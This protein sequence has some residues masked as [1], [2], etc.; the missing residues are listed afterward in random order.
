M[1]ADL[2]IPVKDCRRNKNLKFRPV[3]VP[4]LRNYR[5]VFLL[6]LGCL[7]AT[8]PLSPTAGEALTNSLLLSGSDWWIQGEPAGPGAQQGVFGAT[9]P[10]S[11]W[12]PAT[13]PGNVQADLEEAH[14]LKPLWYGA[15]DS[16]L[17]D[18]AR[19]NWWYRKDFAIP[20][21]FAGKRLTLVFDGV[22]HE[23]E[24]W[25]NRRKI[26]SHVGMFR[27]F[28]SD[29]TELIK[30]GETNRLAVRVSQIPDELAPLIPATDGPQST[31]FV[32]AMNRSRQTLKE[33][34]SPTNFGWDWGVNVWTLGIWKD[35][36]L[37]A[38]GPARIDWTRVQTK[39]DNDCA[40]ATVTAILAV[41]CLAEQGA[42]V[43]CRV[44]GNGQE[45]TASSKVS[46]K[47]G[48][49]EVRLELALD[50]PALW[51]CQGQGAQPLYTLEVQLRPE[52]GGRV[53]DARSIRFGLRDVRWVLTE[54]A[55]NDYISRFQ[56]V[57]NGR[58]V[59]TMGSCLIPPDLLFGRSRP[60]S[61]QLLHRAR[62]A[63]VNML[64]LWGGGIILSEDF[65]ALADELGIMLS[66]EF[67]IANC[68]PETNAVF[69]ANLEATTRNIVRQV[70]N[71]PAIIE[72]TGGNEMSWNS[73][74]RHPAWELFQRIVSEEDDRLIRATCPDLGATH[75]PWDFS[76]GS[77]YR[78][79]NAAQTMRYGEFGTQTPANLEVWH[80]TIPPQSQWPIQGESEPILIRKNVVQAVFSPA[81]WLLKGRI[82]SAF[83][84]LDNLPCLVEAGQFLGAEGLRYAT[85]ALRR[86]GRHLGGFTTWDFN[87]PWPNGAGSYL[88]DYDGRPLMNYDFFR[89]ALAP[90]SLSLKYDS[91]LYDP[92]AGIQLEVW[93][94][95]DAPAAAKN[96]Q[97]QLLARD[98]RGKVFD[99]AQGAAAINPWEASLLQAIHLTPPKETASGP[100][101]VEM[102]LHDAQ[103]KLL[104]ERLHVFGSGAGD[105]GA[106][107][108]MLVNRKAD[109][110]DDV[111]GKAPPERPNGPANLA[112]VGNGAKPATTSSELPGF[113]IHQAKGLNDGIY[114]NDHSWIA[115][116][117]HAWFQID[118]GKIATVGR[119][120]LGRDR[121]GQFYDRGLDYLKIEVSVERP[122]ME[123]HL[124][125]KR[126]DTVARLRSRRHAGNSDR[127]CRG[128]IRSGDRGRG[129]SGG[130]G[131]GLH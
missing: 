92:A 64:R 103:D 32:E 88:V 98:R 19:T 6:V 74:T 112:F 108:G 121:T 21:A 99:H 126:P 9:V 16:R 104:V 125:A 75:S 68:T 123:N 49:N 96:L 42:Q 131:A 27:R 15:G 69:L 36:H 124:R 24:V 111:A 79:Y 109:A 91:I 110:N 10:A 119:F 86:K 87:E 17:Y 38:S 2:R 80:R 34:K 58:P 44:Y 13:V 26:G 35:V 59:R 29:V 12:I 61:L 47:P 57:L 4:L 129:R 7:P 63:G 5:L 28:W 60:R 31:G 66:L 52:D 93:L 23:C 8:M 107:G 83:G 102:Q 84:A 114:G 3:Q 1:K 116:L 56:L 25:L 120:K 106:L 48:A 37:A 70:R 73:L 67:P 115:A 46:L 130:Q 89:Q 122:A 118:L 95:S 78:H 105:R 72:Y 97:W 45:S 33:L 39:L 18:V 55:P 82:D 50:H 101:F 22:D 90:V 43:R 40:K 85:D 100:I 62:A 71:H 117:P 81:H 127:L 20:P 76:I 128:A 53:M 94:A 51:W 30:P 41:D 77:G 113:P 65:Y 54:G 11:G 14:L